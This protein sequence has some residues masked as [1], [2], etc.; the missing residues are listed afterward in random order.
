MDKTVRLLPAGTVSENEINR[1]ISGIREKLSLGHDGLRKVRAQLQDFTNSYRR[2][3]V[4]PRDGLG[5]L[6]GTRFRFNG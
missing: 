5:D 4:A 2:R 3:H 1:L 6:G